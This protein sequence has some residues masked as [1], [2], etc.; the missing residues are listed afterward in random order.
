MDENLII[1]SFGPIGSLNVRLKKITILIGDQGTGKS[2]VAKLFSTFKWLE[3]D[4]MMN[5]NKPDFYTKGDAFKNKLCHYH[6]IDS[7]IQEKTFIK[8]E[9]SAYVFIYE[10]SYRIHALHSVMSSSP[11]RMLLNQ[12]LICLSEICIINMILSIL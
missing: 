9:S 2:C 5:R 1:K 4:L 6:R 3:K 12:D 10:K 11:Q 8:Y 7:F